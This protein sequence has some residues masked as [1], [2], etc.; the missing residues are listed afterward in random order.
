M[1]RKEAK[2]VEKVERRIWIY[3]SSLIELMKSN[4]LNSDVIDEIF[5]DL[6]TLIRSIKQKRS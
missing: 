2:L 5:S 1:D 4:Q 6:L 3:W